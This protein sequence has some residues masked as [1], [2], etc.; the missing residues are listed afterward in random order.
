MSNSRSIVRQFRSVA[1]EPA[2]QSPMEAT[3]IRALLRILPLCLLALV[4]IDCNGI[5][6]VLNNDGGGQPVSLAVP[7]IRQQ[8]GD[9]CWAASSEMVLR[10]YGRQ[11]SQ[12]DILSTWLSYS[13]CSPFGIDPIC[14]VA[15]PNMVTV[16]DTVSYFGGPT[17][18]LVSGPPGVAVGFSQCQQIFALVGFGVAG[19]VTPPL[20]PVY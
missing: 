18:T 7:E 9:W 5:D 19:N 2:R 15:A 13:C 11:Y 4:A 12:C 10:Y 1:V 8:T 6:D 14:D 20:R 17:S 3:V 16:Q